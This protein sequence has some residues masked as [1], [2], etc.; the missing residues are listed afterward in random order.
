MQALSQWSPGAMI[1][2]YVC[3]TER[4]WGWSCQRKIRASLKDV[5]RWGWQ[6]MTA[7]V[8]CP[9]SRQD[10]M[11][12]SPRVLRRGSRPRV[13]WSRQVLSRG[14]KLEALQ[15]LVR[16]QTLE[17]SSFLVSAPDHGGRS[18]HVLCYGYGHAQEHAEASWIVRWPEQEQVLER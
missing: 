18:D 8:S 14:S 17:Q 16:V 5:P 10:R 13:W 15:A 3:G 4:R 9:W 2:G 11:L 6:Q 7:E 12:P 1:C